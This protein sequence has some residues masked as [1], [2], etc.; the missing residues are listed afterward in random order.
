MDLAARSLA[1]KALEAAAG[2]QGLKFVDV[3]DVALAVDD[4]VVD[5]ETGEVRGVI[6]ALERLTTDRPHLLVDGK[7]N[8]R[9]SSPGSVSSDDP[10]RKGAME[11][12][13][14]EFRTAKKNS[15]VWRDVQIDGV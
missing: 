12:T 15:K 10:S 9:T 13:D 7:R 5:S 14:A 2:N 3:R 4:V 11:M 1:I 6:G 8:G